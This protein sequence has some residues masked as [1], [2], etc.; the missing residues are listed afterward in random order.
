ML[1]YHSVDVG[2]DILFIAL[3]GL[4]SWIEGKEHAA[5][6]LCRCRCTRNRTPSTTLAKWPGMPKPCH[7]PFLKKTVPSLSTVIMSLPKLTF[8]RILRIVNPLCLTSSYLFI[9]FELI[10]DSPIDIMVPLAPKPS[11]AVALQAI[12]QCGDLPR[13]CTMLYPFWLEHRNRRKILANR[14]QTSH[15]LKEIEYR[16]VN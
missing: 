4:R 6:N 12:S 9:H 11:D 16:Y 3:P 1:E 8:Q 7:I 5:S 10:N 15:H 14:P 2:A 13:S